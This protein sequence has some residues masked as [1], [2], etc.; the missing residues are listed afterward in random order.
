M[1]EQI[2]LDHRR[3]RAVCMAVAQYIELNPIKSDQVQKP[4]D[5]PWSSCRANISSK[6][7]KIV[8]GHTFI[9]EFRNGVTDQ[10]P[11]SMPSPDTTVVTRQT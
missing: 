11:L 6:G 9:G 5:Y 1:A 3:G 2:F 4:E 7:D 8:S 10:H